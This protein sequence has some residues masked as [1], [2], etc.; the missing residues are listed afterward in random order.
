M[1]GGSNLVTGD[2]NDQSDAFVYSIENKTITRASVSST[3]RQA[4]VGVGMVDISGN[5]QYVVFDSEAT[6]LVPGETN[7]NSDIFLRVSVVR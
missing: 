2:T 5:G 6:N 3:G 1:S 7:R 4:N